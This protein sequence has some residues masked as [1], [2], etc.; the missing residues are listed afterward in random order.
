MLTRY[1]L[2]PG[3]HATYTSVIQSDVGGAGNDVQVHH[4]WAR[5]D[6]PINTSFSYKPSVGSHTCQAGLRDSAFVP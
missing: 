4:A 2:K 3:E 1:P 5:L 6:P